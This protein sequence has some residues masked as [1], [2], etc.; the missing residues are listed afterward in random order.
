MY[1]IGE[2]LGGRLAGY[3][4]LFLWIVVPLVGV[5]YTNQGYHQKYTELTLPQALGLTAMSDFPS[6]VMLAVSAYFALRTIQGGTWSDGM[7]AGLFAGFGVGIKP[8]SGLYLLALVIGLLASR[9]WRGSAFV[10]G[11]LAVPL[12]ALLVWKWRGLGYV[13]LFHASGARPL[14]L[15]SAGVVGA[16]LNTSKYFHLDWSHLAQNIDLLREHFW[17]GRFAVWLVIAGVVAL[18]RR[19]LPAMLLLGGWF[20]AFGIIKGADPV[21][22]VQDSSLLRML[23]AAIPAFVLLLAA[24]PLLLPRAPRRLRPLEA[25]PVWGTRRLRLTVVVAASLLFGLVPVALAARA[26]R[27]PTGATS[28]FFEQAGPIPTERSLS[29]EASVRGNRVTLQWAKQA[30]THAS[31]AYELWRAPLQSVQQ[32]PTNPPGV[33]TRPTF[34][35]SFVDVV[36]PKDAG[37]YVYRVLVAAAWSKD[38]TQA[39]GYVASLP[40]VVRVR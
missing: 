19:S 39:D 16:G 38:P 31:F 24:L 25:P 30:P 5:L 12:L 8:S 21:G 36:A 37:A 13:P 27:L 20:L 35:T 3:W 6:M 34:G 23:I 10:A 1:G 33:I 11:G 4:V 22:S 40:V 28:I 32:Y 7:L 26:H 14:A 29:L 9:R 15:G 2:R 17:S 18:G